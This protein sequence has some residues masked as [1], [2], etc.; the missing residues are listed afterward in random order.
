MLSQDLILQSPDIP[1]YNIIARLAVIRLAAGIIV[2]PAPLNLHV[3][4]YFFNHEPKLCPT[5]RTYQ[6]S[7]V[8][9]D[10]QLLYC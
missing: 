4:A 9:T 8:L 1:Y 2:I 7:P 6:T 3:Y 10:S 5:S